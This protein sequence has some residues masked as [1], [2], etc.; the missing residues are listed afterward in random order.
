MRARAVY[1]GPM[2]STSLP[3]FLRAAAAKAH[4]AAFLVSTSLFLLYILG[5]VQGFLDATQYFLLDAAG[6]TLWVSFV[7]GV[8]HIVLRIASGIADRRFRLLGFLVTLLTAA[9]SGALAAVVSF[10]NAMVGR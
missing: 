3:A 1:T 9:L 6:I 7:S 2:E 4:G 8:A 5:N 10:L